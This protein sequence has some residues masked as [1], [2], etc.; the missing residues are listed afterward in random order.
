MPTGGNDD[1]ESRTRLSTT[2][3]L[4]RADKKSKSVRPAGSQLGETA[5]RCH[6]SRCS[7]CARGQVCVILKRRG[8]TTG[9]KHLMKDAIVKSPANTRVTARMA[10]S[11][12]VSGVFEHRGASKLPQRH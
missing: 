6:V 3:A 11:L 8:A 7:A 2:K 10:C 4:L 9:S 5:V 1:Y 12:A